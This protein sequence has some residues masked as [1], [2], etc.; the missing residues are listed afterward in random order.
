M[1]HGAGLL[2]VIAVAGALLIGVHAAHSDD[3][4]H[5][6]SDTHTT[7]SGHG[8]TSL[9]DSFRLWQ[10]INVDTDA[11]LAYF[12]PRQDLGMCADILA[13]TRVAIEQRHVAAAPDPTPAGGV[14]YC[15][16][17]YGD[18]SCYWETSETALG[19]HD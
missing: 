8:C 18:P 15:V 11:A 16:R 14:Y 4:A 7:A 19:I 13:G 3:R 17:P 9:V 5:L 2:P 10:L 12:K 1:S 6:T